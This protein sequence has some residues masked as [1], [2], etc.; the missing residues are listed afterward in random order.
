MFQTT[1]IVRS[2]SGPLPS[3]VNPTLLFV[4]YLRPVLGAAGTGD[5]EPAVGGAAQLHPPSGQCVRVRP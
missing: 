3:E 1:T 4:P 5:R 2:P